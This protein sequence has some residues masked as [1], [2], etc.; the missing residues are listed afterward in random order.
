MHLPMWFSWQRTL[1]PLSVTRLPYHLPYLAY[2][3]QEM[4]NKMGK[5]DE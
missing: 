4:D 3:T 2:K 5:L 1:N